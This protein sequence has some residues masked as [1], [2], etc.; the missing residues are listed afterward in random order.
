M[1]YLL[2]TN[3]LITAKNF[4]Y[5]FDFCPAFWEWIEGQHRAGVVFS[6]EQVRVEIDRGNDE[7][8]EWLHRLPDSFFLQ[9]GD[10]SAAHFKA[11]TAWASARNY[12]SDRIS[13][14]LGAADYYLVAQALETGFAIVTYEAFQRPGGKIQIPDVCG[15][16][17]VACMPPYEM[18]RRENARFVL[19][20][21]A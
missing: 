16:L 4:H 19:G 17:G 14:F 18:L 13:A 6:V 11:V 5:G 21:S 12:S 1:P 10:D 2:D 8:A 3:V 7:L 20:A 15:G 9:P